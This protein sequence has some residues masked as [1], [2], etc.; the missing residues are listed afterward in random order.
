MKHHDNG[1]HYGQQKNKHHSK[2]NERNEDDY[3]KSDYERDYNTDYRDHAD[4]IQNPVDNL[5][6][7]SA[8]K[9][10]KDLR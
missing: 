10:K 6:D 9:F 8:D 3:E 4:R 2:R 1:N 7:Y 5:I